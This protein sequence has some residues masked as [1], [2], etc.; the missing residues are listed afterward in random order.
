MVALESLMDV[1]SV[2]RKRGM[3]VMRVFNTQPK[4]QKVVEN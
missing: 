1:A 2:A 3:S 4:V